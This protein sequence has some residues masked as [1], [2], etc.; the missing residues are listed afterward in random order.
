MVLHVGAFVAFGHIPKGRKQTSVAIALAEAKKKAVVEK[1][2]T[3]PPKPKPVVKA[4]TQVPAAPKPVQAEPPPPAKAEPPPP[5][6]PKVGDA[7]EAMSGFADLGLSMGGGTGGMAVPMGNGGEGQ[8]GAA[9]AKPTASQAPVTRKVAEL[10]PVDSAPC[11][12][13]LVKPKMLSQVQPA[14]TPEAQQANVEGKVKLEVT[15][16][17]TG[18]VT[19]VKVLSG[20]GFGLDEAA[21]AAVKQWTFSPA[22]KCGSVVPTTI[23]MGVSFGLK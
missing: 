8:G 1:E 20:L 16:D 19:G 11:A 7:P 23:K 15:I 10:A 14:Y 5:S 2:K 18:H 17:A 13:D 6:P 3:E 12:E 21:A 9:P 4:A 22:V